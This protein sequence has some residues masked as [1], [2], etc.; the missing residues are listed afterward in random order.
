ME[1]FSNR[2]KRCV[3]KKD[4]VNEYIEKMAALLKKV[5]G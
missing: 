2:D 4:A 3:I 1:C 5:R